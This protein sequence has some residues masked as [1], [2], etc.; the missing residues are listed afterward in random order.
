MF[1][2][3]LSTAYGQAAAAAKPSAIETTV[4]PFVAILVLYYLFA[5]KP[6][7]KKMKEQQNFLSNLKK[8]DQVVTSGGIHGEITGVSEKII[9]LQVADNVRIKIVRNQIQGL[10]TK[11]GTP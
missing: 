2:L 6:Q 7:Q 10:V 8:G 3:F 1:G 9:T 5:G 4:I 11:E